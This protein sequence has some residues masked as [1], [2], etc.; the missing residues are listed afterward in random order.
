MSLLVLQKGQLTGL[1]VERCC[2]AEAALARPAN[3]FLE[4]C[5]CGYQNLREI[6]HLDCI[7][8]PSVFACALR[9]ARDRDKLVC[10]RFAVC[11]G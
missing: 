1:I 3:S 9:C 2:P 8:P 5:K 10:Q 4:D 7:V 6:R 11:F